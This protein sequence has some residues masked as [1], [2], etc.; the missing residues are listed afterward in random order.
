MSHLLRDAR[1][2][3]TDVSATPPRQDLEPVQEPLKPSD[4]PFDVGSYELLR[5]ATRIVESMIGAK[6]T[7]TT[8]KGNRLVYRVMGLMRRGE[9]LELEKLRSRHDRGSYPQCFILWD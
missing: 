8:K 6:R 3:L 7:R 5:R 4:E 1:G 2:S 9:T